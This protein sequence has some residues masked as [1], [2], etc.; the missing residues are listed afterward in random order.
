MSPWINGFTWNI[1]R[2]YAAR[3]EKKKLVHAR[4]KKIPK[5]KNLALR[6]TDLQCISCITYGGDGGEECKRRVWR[7]S[8]PVT[9]SSQ[10]ACA[11]KY[12]HDCPSRLASLAAPITSVVR[13]HAAI[14][15]SRSHRVPD[16]KAA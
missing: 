9:L 4:S 6:S 14:S 3:Y 16:K 1:K 10:K 13:R 12:Q 15:R 11:P 5:H 7:G 8:R 2:P